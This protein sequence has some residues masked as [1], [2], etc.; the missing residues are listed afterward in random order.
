MF[1]MFWLS[2]TKIFAATIEFCKRE[3]RENEFFD[4]NTIAKFSI[5]KN[6]GRTL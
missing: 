6:R 5:K 2:Y 4:N 3:Y 1:G